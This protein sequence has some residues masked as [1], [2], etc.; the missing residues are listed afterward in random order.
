MF[1]LVRQ[2]LAFV[3]A[4]KTCALDSRNVNKDVTAASVRRDK[5]KT[6]GG[7][8]PFN[9]TSSHFN[10]LRKICPWKSPEGCRV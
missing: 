5:T 4:T 8:K 7:V 6:L 2:S 3:Q 9:N 1:N 10:D